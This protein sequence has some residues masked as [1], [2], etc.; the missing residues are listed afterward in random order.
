MK[1]LILLILGIGNL[2]TVYAVTHSLKYFYTGVSGDINFPEFTVVGMVDDVQFM[3]FDSNT[4]T[5]VPKVEWMKRE[6]PK[7]WKSETHLG[8]NRHQVFK[9]NIQVL[10]DRFNQSMSTGV[11]VFQWQY[12]CEWDDETGVSGVFDQYGY[13]GEDF[14]SLD[15]KTLIWI[16][17]KQQAVITKTK[18]EYERTENE[19][20]KQYVTN[21]CIV[22]VKKYVDYGKSSLMRTVPPSVSLLQKTPS[23]PVTCHATGFYPSRVM[24]TWKKD[25][26][27]HHE[28]V[29]MGEILPNDDGTFQTSVR[30]NV[31]PEER[32]NNKYQCV[33]QVAGINEDFIKDL[34]EDT[35]SI[36]PIIGVVVAGF[37]VIIAVVI[38]VVIWKKKSKKGFAQTNT[39]DTDFDNSERA[40]QKI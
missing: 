13:D 21:G 39:S 9:N 15:Q 11:H 37:L 23:S 6:G 10:K 34:T 30:L 4:Q 26:Q 31:K 16:A 35:T 27:E 36:G 40:A 12:G 3:Y 19:I 8:I 5:A 1:S 25:G 29:E 2:H 14:I 20:L 24:V 38:G 32:K 33:V 7:Y 28:D 22:W 18:W 17:S